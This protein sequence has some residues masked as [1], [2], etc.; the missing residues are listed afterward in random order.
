MGIMQ[1]DQSTYTAEAARAKDSEQVR[2]RY[3]RIAPLY[4]V[5]ERPMEARAAVWR[6]ELLSLARGSVLEVGV[7][8][9]KNLSH[10]PAGV[11]VTGID[12]SGAM[13]ERARKRAEESGFENVTLLEMD[14]EDLQFEDNSFDTVVTSCVF[15]SVP[16]PVAGL[17]EIRRVCKPGGSVLMLEH[18]RSEKPL[19]GPIMD[20]LNPVP[21]HLYGANINRR[22]V[23][24]LRLAG[25]RDIEVT[26]L[27][28]DVVK[29]IIA[30]PPR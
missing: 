10:Y 19:L 9:G 18:V 5:L 13:I 12:F 20:L 6:R 14:A 27:W 29:R 1:T 16:L 3:N 11:T 2:K 8:T 17:R 7:G 4:D 30:R 23:E 26:D 21:L 22:T 24:N 28:K 15:C 25:F